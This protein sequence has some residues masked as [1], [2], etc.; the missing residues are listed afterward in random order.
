MPTTICFSYPPSALP[1]P[2]NS[3]SA[4]PPLPGMRRVPLTCYSY[5]HTCFDYPGDDLPPGA[6]NRGAVRRTP[7][8]LYRMPYGTCYRY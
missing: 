8:A 2:G 4:Q 3:R 5:P 6:A 1:G 7:S